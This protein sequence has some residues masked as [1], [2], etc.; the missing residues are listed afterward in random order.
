MVD[1]DSPVH[2]MRSEAI[3]AFEEQGFPSKRDEAWK[4][5]SLNQCIKT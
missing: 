2:D 3:K 5:T 1:V 4:Y